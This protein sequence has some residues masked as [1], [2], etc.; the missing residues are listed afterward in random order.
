MIGGKKILAVTLARGGSKGVSKKNIRPLG[1]VP[2]IA[3]TILQV[4]DSQYID[5]YIVSTDCTEIADVAEKY[6]ARIPFVRPAELSTDTASSASAL[7]HAVDYLED[8]EGKSFDYV[9]ELMATNPF[10]TTADIDECIRQTISNGYQC[11]VAVH[12]LWDQHPSR[13]KMI[14]DNVLVDFFPEVPESRRQDL[15][16][17]AYIR[18]G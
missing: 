8:E 7:I 3:H 5:E 15:S 12:R 18:S 10:K 16:P 13:V 9:V 14:R 11:G 1:G 2:L 4:R 17:P 6:G